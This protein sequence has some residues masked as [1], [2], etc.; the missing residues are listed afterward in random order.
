MSDVLSVCV[1]RTTGV[2]VWWWH[3]LCGLSQCSLRDTAIG[4]SGASAIAGALVHVPQ[5]QVLKYVGVTVW[6]GGRVAFALQVHA[7][8]LV[9]G[10]SLA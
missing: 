7:R 6:G 9:R 8:R 3:V 5:L 4:D 2:S 1:W 10:D